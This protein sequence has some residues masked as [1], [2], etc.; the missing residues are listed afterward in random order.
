MKMA[1]F[2]RCELFILVGLALL[3]C[4]TP[5]EPIKRKSEWIELDSAEKVR[6]RNWPQRKSD[7]ALAAIS[8]H[9][10]R[11]TEVLVASVKLRSGAIGHY[12]VPFSGEVNLD[13]DDFKPF[14]LPRGAVVIGTYQSGAEQLLVVVIHSPVRR[15]VLRVYNL[16]SGD[17][18]YESADLTTSVSSGTLH[19]RAGNKGVWIALKHTEQRFS[20]Y[21]LEPSRKQLVGPYGFRHHPHVLTGFTGVG[22]SAVVVT[23]DSSAAAKSQNISAKSI[24]LSATEKSAREQ[25]ISLPIASEVESVAA[26]ALQDSYLVAYVDGDSMIGESSMKIAKIDLKT[27]KILSHDM[28][29]IQDAHVS[30]PVFLP[31]E[32][33]RLGVLKWVDGESTFATYKVGVVGSNI[34][35]QEPKVS[36]VFAAGSRIMD[37]FSSMKQKRF[38]TVRT[39]EGDAWTY[40]LCG[41]ASTE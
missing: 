26:Y 16:A 31:V 5:D 12:S 1:N 6:C 24:T 18:I 41:L 4:E 34:K 2:M 38:V 29:T 19:Q 21:W 13:P 10:G 9:Q 3:G 36:G 15:P 17:Q 33:V 28:V 14:E 39:R 40:R 25:T 23:L 32:P 27:G 20:V 22:D 30:E 37:V 35:L 7:L 8:T 11:A